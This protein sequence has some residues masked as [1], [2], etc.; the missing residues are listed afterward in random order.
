MMKTRMK[1]L[2]RLGVAGLFAFSLGLAPALLGSTDASAVPAAHPVTVPD[3]DLTTE[4]T[5]TIH[6]YLTD[7]PSTT[8]GTGDSS[9]AAKI[10]SG[11]TKLSN[12]NFLVKK[13]PLDKD[14]NTFDGFKAAAAMTVAQAQAK[15]ESVEGEKVT[16]VN[17]EIQVTEIQGAKLT[18]GVYLI[19]E[20]A[21]PH[22]TPLEKGKTLV[23][24]APF[25]V[26]LP[27][28]DPE[29]RTSWNYDVH[30][31]PKN[32]KTGSLKTVTDRNTAENPGGTP[33][34]KIEDVQAGDSISFDIKADVPPFAE[35]KKL[36]T[37]TFTD[38]LDPEKLEPLNPTNPALG[39]EEVYVEGSETNSNL[40]ENTDYEV[41]YTAE[42]Q[43][44]EVALT[45]AGLTKV[46]GITKGG[47][48]FKVV[49][50]IVAKVKPFS[51]A[52]T[53]PG[54][55]ENTATVVTNNG[56]GKVTTTTNTTE[57]YHGKLIIHKQDKDKKPLEG[58]VF[59]L[60]K[61]TGTSGNIKLEGNM[62]MVN[63]V[64]EWETGE[65]GEVAIEGLHVTDFANSAGVSDP[66]FDYCLVETKAPEG[67][68]LLPEPVKVSFAKDELFGDG[69]TTV[70]VKT[71]EIENVPTTTPW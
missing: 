26:M 61:C 24:A 11:A 21:S 56:S 15:T 33:V 68:E 71:V 18:P 6:K 58:A 43:T 69:V 54:K 34:E 49:V 65:N 46:G 64:S 19:Q 47:T 60:Y 1:K 39:V 31:F 55:I 28:T 16:T 44:Y 22:A 2:M 32:Q 29:F 4:G 23:P 8:P 10:P 63:D 50:T 37:F 35:G 13:V 20:E 5:I 30:V 7:V 12:V 42:T 45:E 66:V 17:G 27:I 62:I 3:I 9:D 40:I 38:S 41:T 52:V 59:N 70:G 36:E 51:D 48:G 67:Y 57:T 25:L 14:I 53:N